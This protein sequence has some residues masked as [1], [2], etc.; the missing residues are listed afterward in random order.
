MNYCRRLAAV[1]IL[2]LLSACSGSEPS[3]DH[4]VAESQ[5][6]TSGA[7]AAVVTGSSTA[8]PATATATQLPNL[9]QPQENSVFRGDVPG[10]GYL[11]L[12]YHGGVVDIAALRAP[13]GADSLLVTCL[14]TGG[15][16]SSAILGRTDRGGPL[17]NGVFSVTETKNL[18]A[19]TFELTV[20][21]RYEARTITGTMAINGSGCNSGAKQ[22]TATFQGIGN[23]VLVASQQ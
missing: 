4:S 10:I 11:I 23:E 22:F 7:E 15:F 18:P 8:T 13:P 2:L 20:Q 16:S 6:S 17:L 12:T 19:T 21:G 5:A 1:A 3:G 14:R 9:N